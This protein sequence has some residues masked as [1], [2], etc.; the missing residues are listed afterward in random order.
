MELECIGEFSQMGLEELRQKWKEI[1]TKTI[2]NIR[3]GRDVLRLPVMHK[4]NFIFDRKRQIHDAPELFIQLRGRTVFD[5]PDERLVLSSMEVCYIPRKMPHFEQGI[6]VED[7]FSTLFMNLQRERIMVHFGTLDSENIPRPGS[8][9]GIFNADDCGEVWNGLEQLLRTFSGDDIT[10]PKEIIATL[11]TYVKTKLASPDDTQYTNVDKL[12]V[13]CTELIVDEFS[14]HKLSVKSL[15][16][17]LEVSPNHLSAKFVQELGFTLTSYLI[18]VRLYRVKE[19]L[20]N[21]TLR[22][23]EIAWASGFRSPNYMARAFKNKYGLTPS[24]FRQK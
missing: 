24:Q 5:L 2:E 6:R 9:W 19:L 14:D 11:L 22:I 13:K 1:L 21:S 17:K 18:S 16:N 15:A 3:Q 7:E 12:I 20:Q 23:S 8:E 4:K 10:T